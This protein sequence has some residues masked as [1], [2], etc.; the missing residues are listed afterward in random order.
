MKLSCLTLLLIPG[1]LS[2][3]FAAPTHARDAAPRPNVLFI[4]IDDLRPA[5]GCYGDPVAITPSIDQLAGRGIVF[6]RA[7]C[8]QAVCCPSRLS[9]LTGRRPDT[10]RV[11]DLRT[12]FRDAAPNLVTLPQHFKNR[13]MLKL[14]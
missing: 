4:A 9:L 10:I 11:W 13:A 6:H 12:H 14:V 2:L 1:L 8:Q 7:Y 5:L 3:A